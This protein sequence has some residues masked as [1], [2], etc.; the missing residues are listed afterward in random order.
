IVR[1]DRPS[2]LQFARGNP[3][4]APDDVLGPPAAKRY[5]APLHNLPLQLTSF[6]GREQ[7]LAAIGQLLHANR[8]LTLSGPGGSGKTRLAL[9]TSAAHLDHYPDG[10]WWVE[11]APLADPALL[12][13]SIATALGIKETRSQLL[14]DLVAEHLRRRKLLL[15]LD[16]CEHLLGACADIAEQLLQTCPGLTI[17]ATSRE[18]LAIAGERVFL[19]PTLS[20]PGLKESVPLEVA[21]E[22]EAVRLFCERAQAGA[23]EMTLT[24]GNATA[25]ATI[26]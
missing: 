18:R 14:T 13:Q 7:V 19:V 2:F 26:C 11:L 5:R 15:L 22:S 1:D 17:L 4:A 20:S 10:V 24:A 25:I 9:Q 12:P 21:A 16:N 8:L 23:P 3:F 6:I